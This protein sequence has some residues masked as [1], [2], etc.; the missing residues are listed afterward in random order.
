MAVADGDDS[1][2]P[3]VVLI[4]ELCNE[5][6]QLQ[7]NSIKKLSTITLA[8]GVERT[9]SELLPFLTDTIYD[10][11]EVLLTLAKQLGT[12]TTLVSLATVEETVV[13]DKAVESLRATSHEHSPSD[14][15]VHFMPLVKQLAGGDRFTSQTLACGL[16][17]VCYP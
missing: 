9:R 15:E 14:L 17:S 6:V 8:L 11:D 1:L 12:F 5:D 3:S 7:L 10:E 2:Y 13:W 16:F 4:D